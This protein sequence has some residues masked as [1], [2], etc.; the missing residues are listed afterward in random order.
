[1]IYVV[2]FRQRDHFKSLFSIIDLLGYEF[3]D[4]MN[5]LPF[6]TIKF[7]G[8][9][10]ATRKGDVILLNTVLNK[11]ISEANKE[12]K[13]RKRKG[14]PEK[15]GVGAIKYMILKNEPIKDV[16]FS[17]EQALSF[18][19][20]TGPYLQYSYAR[21]C[22]IIKKANKENFNK[23][24][25]KTNDIT[26]EEFELIKK[27][28]KF[29]EVVRRSGRILDPS[30]IANYSFELCQIFNEFYHSNHVIGDSREAI[31]LRIIDSFRTC[32][33]NSLWLLGIEVM[34]EM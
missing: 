12:I 1:M 20:N 28:S 25:P 30:I 6:G 21:A 29:P 22:S 3:A 17:W 16:N 34:D 23:G 33:K 24:D 10:M 32:L 31:R 26:H 11:T 15:V 4:K 18:E 2:D 19:G 27:I 13:K 7:D 9:I 8:K 5:H 14:D